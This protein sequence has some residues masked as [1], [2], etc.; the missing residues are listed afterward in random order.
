MD[1]TVTLSAPR[2]RVVEGASATVEVIITRNTFLDAVSVTVAGLPTG[3]S[4]DA[5]TIEGDRG[6]LT[7]RADVGA[8]QG[9]AALMVTAAGA[10]RSHDTPLSMLA[11]GLPGTLDQSFQAITARTGPAGRGRAVIVQPDGKILTVSSVGLGT[12]AGMRVAR[13]LSNGAPDPEFSGGS[14]LVEAGGGTAA[15]TLQD[16]GKI[17]VV[18]GEQVAG[19]ARGLVVRLD[20]SGEIDKKFGTNGRA[21]L[22][23]ADNDEAAATLLSAVALQR[24]GGI[25]ISGGINGSNSAGY[26]AVVARLTPTGALD[27]TFGTMGIA[28]SR[29]GEYASYD[30]IA[31]QSDGRIVTI[32][33]VMID[34]IFHAAFARLTTAGR[35]DN[36]F[37]GDGILTMDGLLQ[38]DYQFTSG[39]GA[40]LVIQADGKIAAVGSAGPPPFGSI[41]HSYL[42][43][44]NGDDGSPDASF[45]TNGAK[46]VTLGPSDHADGLAIL[47]DNKWLVI[48]AAGDNSNFGASVTRFTSDALLD[49]S[50]AGGIAIAK[51]TGGAAFRAITLDSEGRILMTGGYIQFDDGG[52][53][54][55]ENFILARM[56]Q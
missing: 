52:N 1:F 8:T 48:G 24:D 26:F 39:P 51:D 37:S 50:F 14:V 20:S 32:G 53:Y 4:A 49:L 43:R 42:M 44:L 35:P 45:G 56:W 17:I 25:I 27:P 54:A 41:Y 47:P 7:V 21:R 18:G 36:S 3:V 31:I 46:A 55:S 33:R 29:Q 11:M 40:S 23:L 9:E 16:D 15:L 34:N 6:T 5:L 13:F 12:P 2:I 28:R 22:N 38:D 10:G 30:A 19:R